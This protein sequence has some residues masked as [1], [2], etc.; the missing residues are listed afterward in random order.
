MKRF[1]VCAAMLVLILGA[2]GAFA[3]KAP[4]V[5]AS[6]EVPLDGTAVSLPKM[7]SEGEYKVRII[8][9]FDCD[10]DGRSFD[11]EYRTDAKG[12]FN[13]PHDLV[14]VEPI[15]A[16]LLDSNAGRHTYTYGPLAGE[17]FAGESVTVRVNVDKLV[18]EFIRTPSE[19][20][21]SLSGAMKAELLHTPATVPPGILLAMVG[22][23]LLIVGLV[24]GVMVDASRKAAKR[25]YEDVNGMQRRIGRKCEEA[26][27]EI[28]TDEG[29]F[30]QL[31]D[32]VTQ[33]AEGADELAGHIIA[34]RQAKLVQSESDIEREIARLQREMQRER[35]DEMVAQ[36]AG[37]IEAKRETLGHLQANQRSESEY[38]LRLAQVETTVDNLRLKLPRLRVQLAETGADQAAVGDIDR[39]LELL[40]TAI[41][42]TREHVMGPLPDD[43]E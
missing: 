20:R 32:R 35:D 38:L 30:E 31:R 34:F 26:L 22:L 11:A 5:V 42:E 17:D 1:G 19:V 41:S 40:R 7:E 6:A 33:L 39:E 14:Q 23:P 15:E 8:G 28:G 13:Q 2:T 43:D 29:L 37:E 9:N 36:Y 27:T 3:A 25:P 18:N 12:E 16:K 24:V 21:D 4:R 10:I